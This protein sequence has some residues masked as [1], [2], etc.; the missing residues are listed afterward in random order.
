MED[1]ASSVPRTRGKPPDDFPG[2]DLA[3]VFL[4]VIGFRQHGNGLDDLK[5]GGLIEILL[6]VD[7]VVQLTDPLLPCCP[8]LRRA[9]MLAK[10]VWCRTNDDHS[11]ESWK[12]PSTLDALKDHGS[13]APTAE[14]GDLVHVGDP[15]TE[16]IDPPSKTAGA[17]EHM[18]VD[19]VASL[20]DRS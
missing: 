14:G 4:F 3:F 12:G 9:A 1:G 19:L 11:V 13:A 6:E 16:L 18:I 17:V 15:A 2:T 8:R 7:K 20:T 5:A 10:R